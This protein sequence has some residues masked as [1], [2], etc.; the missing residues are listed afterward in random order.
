MIYAM[1]DIHGQYQTFLKMLKKINFSDN[2]TLY[3]LGDIIDRGEQPI[4][5]YRYI[6]DRKNIHL[7][8]GN[9]E[10][11]LL[12]TIEEFGKECFNRPYCGSY[13]YSKSYMF[14]MWEAN[15][16]FSTIK[17]IVEDMEQS[18]REEMFDFL[19]NI[20]FY[21]ILDYKDNK[22]ILLCHSCIDFGKD[23]PPERSI[24]RSVRNSDILWNRRDKYDNVPDN[25]III[26]GHTPVQKL[27]RK[28]VIT[29]YNNKQVYDIDCGCAGRYRLACLRIDDMKSFYVDVE[30]N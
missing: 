30:G 2:D 7:L 20:P 8:M 5:I 17:Q 29:C 11:M 4:D 24:A 18:E 27:F 10:Q 9:H 25:Y 12:D 3:I 26:H 21:H 14:R 22:K 15:G 16:G 1:S 28:N 13:F 19:K 23:I 6:K